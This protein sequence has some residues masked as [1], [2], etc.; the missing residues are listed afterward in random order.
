MRSARRKI[1]VL[2]TLSQFGL[3]TDWA[4]AQD[5]VLNGSIPPEQIARSVA[6]SPAALPANPGSYTVQNDLLT[7]PSP[8]ANT[9]PDP[10][11]AG[12]MAS[13][14]APDLAEPDR[15]ELADFDDE[16]ELHLDPN[17]PR[18]IELSEGVRGKLRA[19]SGGAMLGI[20]IGFW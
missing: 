1:L 5:A 15:D 4:S 7:G 19:K 3:V 13:A 20:A 2:A 17:E 14:H 8:L 6:G 11:T 18:S 16:I 10:A 12:W 9:A